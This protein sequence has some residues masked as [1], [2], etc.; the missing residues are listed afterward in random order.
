MKK[1]GEKGKSDT[2]KRMQRR[3]K[4]EEEEMNTMKKSSRDSM[5]TSSRNFPKTMIGSCISF[6]SL[7]CPSN[8]FCAILYTEKKPINHLPRVRISSPA[9]KK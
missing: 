4:E 1:T 9:N 6:T 8:S 7:P 5:I 2:V 3:E